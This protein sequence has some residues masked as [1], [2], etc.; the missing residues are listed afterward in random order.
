MSHKYTVTI[1]EPYYDAFDNT[2]GTS[3]RVY[4][5]DEEVGAYFIPLTSFDP[6]NVYDSIDEFFDDEGWTFIDD[7]A[8]YYIEGKTEDKKMSYI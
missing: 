2:P 6:Q 3:V 8:D 1:S 4:D 7:G 5:L